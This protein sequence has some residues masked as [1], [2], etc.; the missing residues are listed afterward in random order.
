L[1]CD[2]CLHAKCLRCGDGG[3]ARRLED[4]IMATMAMGDRFVGPADF[5]LYPNEK[6]HA[7]EMGWSGE[8]LL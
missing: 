7:F 1:L 6:Y 2:A 5:W 3:S 4:L 8:N